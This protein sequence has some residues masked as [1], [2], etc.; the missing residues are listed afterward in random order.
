MPRPAAPSP[1]P[2][3]PAV[4]P[5]DART[6]PLLLLIDGYSLV[7]RSYFVLAAMGREMHAPDKTPTNALY[8]FT[9]MLLNAVERFDPNQLLIALDAH[10]PSFRDEIYREYKGN[11]E[12][13]PE[14]L[15]IQ[16][17]V[18]REYLTGVG[19]PWLELMGYEADDILGT[20]A[21]RGA[22]AGFDVAV[23]TGD[24]DLLQIVS[25][26]VTVHLTKVGTSDMT[27]FDPAA[28]RAKF[29]V[30]VGQFVD[31]K[32]LLGDTSDNIPGVRGI[33]E[34]TAEKLLNEYASLES[35]LEAASTSAAPKGPLAK[36]AEHAEMAR[37]SRRL[38]EI[39]CTVPLE[40]APAGQPE[41]RFEPPKFK[42]WFARLGF[43]TIAKRYGVEP[44]DAAPL[45]AASV[46]Q[47]EN[48]ATAGES[49]ELVIIDARPA[50]MAQTPSSEVG[51]QVLQTLEEVDGLVATLRAVGRF[52][53]DVETD[54]LNPRTT[55]LVGL[56]F[57]HEPG[58]G[59]YVPVGHVRPDDLLAATSD[60][61]P[62]VNL[63]LA[64]VLARLKPLLEDETIGKIAQNG[65]FE[66]G[67][68]RRYGIALNGLTFD[69]FVASYLLN[70]DERHGL[71]DLSEQHLALVWSR[72][73][74]LIGS[75]KK[76]ITMDQVPISQVAPY[77]VHD[78]VATHRL[79][80]HFAP[81]LAE[82][83]I[84]KLFRE[85]EVPL[86]PVLSDMEF[87]GIRVDPTVLE[88][89]GFQLHER[90]G[91]LEIA[92]VEA[93]GGRSLNLASPKQLSEYLFNILQLPNPKKGS[94]DIEVLEE[95][96]GKDPI[97][98]IVI[99]HRE[100]SKLKGTYIAGLLPLIENDGRIHTNY[101]AGAAATGRLASSNPNLQNIPIRTDLGRRIRKAFVPRNDEYTLISADYSQIEL[102][103]LAH[104]SEDEALMEVYRTGGDIHTETA[105]S[106]LGMD[107]AHPDAEK[108][109]QAK[110]INFGIIYGMGA[111][112]LSK[113][114]GIPQ[115]DAQ[116]FID[117][118]FA[119]FPK[120]RGFFERVKSDGRERGY[121]ETFLG[122]RRYFP[123]LVSANSMRRSMA[124]R[125]AMNMPLQGGASD[126]IKSAMVQLAPWMPKLDS[127][128]LL[129]V[130]DELVFEVPKAR[131]EEA[132]AV[133]GP[134]MANAYPFRIPIQVE[135]KAGPSWYD[136]NAIGTAG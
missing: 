131:Q 70:P 113:S 118:Y 21:K 29:G 46:F 105:V 39:C 60:P 97:I 23:I 95:L 31:Y 34:K 107:P 43:R 74:D 111:F 24:R 132:V 81:Q 19:L 9:T 71:K 130:H 124:E 68:C 69:T 13:A 80:D 90:L 83:P 25:D 44:K 8:S 78:A 1:A 93:T 61:D 66:H 98:E 110:A 27:A 103:L 87:E 99:E 11:R 127:F 40:W 92:A 79:A 65:K 88:Q 32:A 116:S 100:L 109:R 53:F 136:M 12:D 20:M 14:D 47:L 18:L 75:G 89:I 108:R 94:T 52:A 82:E 64:E 133:I 117:G 48:R 122:R 85:I 112:S 54:S 62:Y 42:D 114:L 115:K 86:V 35:M 129:Q 119:R 30:D 33:G 28:V 26:R 104:Y 72:I 67:V 58:G 101:N 128:M 7:F 77:A 106:V 49:D 4:L 55:N 50:A 91:E 15:K 123:E 37:L 56:S 45:A 126:L 76:Q 3:T 102:R 17:E 38:S 120:V 84:G 135:L 22:E 6:R 121:V 41:F 5:R 96:L 10:G 36:L 57:A 63:P 51:V 125:A 16:L 134:Q 73:E 2:A 59:V